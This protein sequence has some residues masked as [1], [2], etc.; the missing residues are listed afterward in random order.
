MSEF[1]SAQSADSAVSGHLRK[2]IEPRTC[3]LIGKEKGTGNI[4]LHNGQYFIV[5]CRHVADD[6]LT[7]S[8]DHYIRLRP[9][10]KIAG[11]DLIHIGSSNDT[12]DIALLKV[13]GDYRFEAA[14]TIDDFDPIDNFSRYDF[15]QDV[16]LV[17]SGFPSEISSQ[18]SDGVWNTHMTYFTIPHAEA[19]PTENFLFLAYPKAVYSPFGLHGRLPGAKGLSGGFVFRA[20]YSK[21]AAVDEI[22]LKVIAVQI[23][24]KP[25]IWAK[26][27]NIKHLFKLFEG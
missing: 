23:T 21:G 1:L 15:H 17:V 4:V 2:Y 18:D 22:Q 8:L 13:H 26:G 5:T 7:N 3:L 10:K 12:I 9:N 11:S 14:Y 6:F 25:H 27:S 20:E 24:W 19:K 16:R